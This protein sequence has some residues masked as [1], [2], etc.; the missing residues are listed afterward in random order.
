[1]GTLPGTM[2]APGSRPTLGLW[3]TTALVIGNT[4]GSGVFLLP[5]ALGAYGSISLVAW[6]FT[7]T[8][9]LMC[10]LVF[11]RLSRRLPRAGGP[12]AYTR[13]GFGEFTGF[14]VAWGYWISCWTTNAALAVAMV[15]YLTVFW[16]SL[17]TNAVLAGA[18]AVGSIWFLTFVN[19]LGVRPVGFL[20]VATT[21]L[22]LT[23]LVGVTAFGLF[24]LD[25]SNFV[26]FNASAQSTGGA[27]TTCVALTLWA[28]LGIESA[29]IPAEHISHPER[30]ISRATLMGTGGIA[31]L[32]IAGTAAVMGI[33]P[34]SRL[35]AST[36][37]FADAA[38]AIW[39]SW[40]GYAVAA[41]AIL[42]C[43]GALNGWILNTAQMSQAIAQDRLFPGI[44][45]RLSRRGMPLFGL[46]VSSILATLLVAVNY[47]KGLVEQFT[48][49][50]LLAT[51]TALVPYVF[52]AASSLIQMSREKKERGHRIPRAAL[53]V[54]VL[55]FL[56]SVWAIAGAGHEIVYWGF[57]LLLAGIPVYV[58]MRWNGNMAPPEPK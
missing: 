33:L 6:L 2:S 31:V 56:Y 29:T 13:E 18:T 30:T 32:Y 17:G 9:S 53:M 46:L 37:P 26:P 35:A 7:A 12:Y 23:P 52:S 41:G 40:A 39:G 58:L 3:M 4:V 24:Y 10:A 21:V 57:L 50:I 11:A 45:G 27:L 34:Q 25:T 36:A 43:F 20:Q 38:E 51:L 44:F 42:S 49:I 54:S 1:M 48:F 15:S 5:A 14:L 19:S 22:K 47:T 8:G 55:A 28:F 16:P